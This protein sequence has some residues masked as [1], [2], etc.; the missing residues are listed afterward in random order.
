LYVCKTDRDWQFLCGYAHDENERPRLVGINQLL[1]R[2]ETLREVV[3]LQEEWEAE[4]ESVGGAWTR[5]RY[6]SGV[7]E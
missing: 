1:A 3:D 4:R 5:S 6:S 2:D 7:E